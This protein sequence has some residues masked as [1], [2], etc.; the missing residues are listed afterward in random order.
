MKPLIDNFRLAMTPVHVCAILTVAVAVAVLGCAAVSVVV[1]SETC[2]KVA[3]ALATE[4][5]AHCSPGPVSAECSGATRV[6]RAFAVACAIARSEHIL[7]EPPSVKIAVPPVDSATRRRRQ[8]LRA[9]SVV[10]GAA[11]AARASRSR[12]AA[13]AVAT[14]IAVMAAYEFTVAFF[15]HI[16]AGSRANMTPGTPGPASPMGCSAGCSA[17]PTAG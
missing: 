9:V 5:R 13:V 7:S 12:F 10:A 3:G 11:F 4:A 6:A 15:Y 1:D 2:R 17:A 8:A 14:A 16:G